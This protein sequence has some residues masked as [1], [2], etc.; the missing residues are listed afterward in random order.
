MQSRPGESPLARSESKLTGLRAGPSQRDLRL[1]LGV[2]LRVPAN[3][4]LA[5][6]LKGQTALDSQLLI[7]LVTVL[8]ERVDTVEAFLGIGVARQ[9]RSSL[10]SVGLRNLRTVIARPSPLSHFPCFPA[11]PL[12]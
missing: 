1:D 5:Q 11:L 9:N 6:V 7:H 4:V 3:H 12:F 2:D 10:W 8:P